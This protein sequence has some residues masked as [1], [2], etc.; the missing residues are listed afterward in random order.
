MLSSF[1][2]DHGEIEIQILLPTPMSTILPPNAAASM[3]FS[4]WRQPH[5]LDH[6]V[7][8]VGPV[9]WRT[10]SAKVLSP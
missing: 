6:N 10:W 2:A 5:R 7:E 3:Q 9:A 4:R 1:S 8:S